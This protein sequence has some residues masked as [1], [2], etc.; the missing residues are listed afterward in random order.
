MLPI[1]RTI[2]PDVIK[3]QALIT[4]PSNSSVIEAVHLMEERHIGAI[5]VVERGQLLGIVTERDVVFRVVAK[6]RDP[7]STLLATVMTCD[8]ETLRPTDTV[9]DALDKMNAGHYRHLPVIE[10]GRLIGIVSVR[11][12]YQNVLD[13]MSTDIILLAEG[14]LGG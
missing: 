4:L 13:Q 2:V 14:L 1:H 5:L 11:D 3:E 9:R 6:G 10:S 12:L 8:P 7:A